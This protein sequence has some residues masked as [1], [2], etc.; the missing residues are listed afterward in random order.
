MEIHRFQSLPRFFVIHLSRW[1]IDH[2][3]DD[4][5]VDVPVRDLDLSRHQPSKLNLLSTTYS[6]LHA[7]G[8][9]M[10]GHYTA[11]CQQQTDNGYNMTTE[12]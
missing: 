6:P 4:R 12:Q 3:K 11:T 2:T 7:F 8:R 5:L 1:N 10:S 9:P